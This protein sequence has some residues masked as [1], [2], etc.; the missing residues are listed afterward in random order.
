MSECFSFCTAEGDYYMPLLPCPVYG[1]T[2]TTYGNAKY[3]L[4]SDGVNDYYAFMSFAN[5]KFNSNVTWN[6]SDTYSASCSALQADGRAVAL[7]ESGHVQSLGHTAD[8]PSIMDDSCYQ[9]NHLHTLSSNS[10]IP[11][12]EGIYPGNQQAG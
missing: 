12:V 9:L 4:N 1:Q 2:T 11:A 5:V 10:D 3:G 6:N 7:H 8:C